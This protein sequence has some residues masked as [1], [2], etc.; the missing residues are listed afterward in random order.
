M[1]RYLNRDNNAFSQARKLFFV[2]KSDC[3]SVLN[4]FINSGLQFICVS[5]PRRFG[6]SR[7][8]SLMNAYYSKGCDS[9]ALFDDLK[10]AKDQSYLENL[11][12][13]D[14]IW[15]D[16]QYEIVSYK[17]NVNDIV[18]VITKNIIK[19]LEENF[20]IEIP[21]TTLAKALAL[22]YDKFKKQFIIIIDE[23]DAIF[24]EHSHDTELEKKY[25]DFLRA[26]FKG[27]TN[28]TDTIA[29]AYITGILPIKRY[30]SQSAL[31]NF[32]EFTMLAP[33]PFITY[34]GF[35]EEETKELCEKNNL[36]YE[37]ACQWYDGYV[38]GG[39]HMLNPNSVVSYLATRKC[40][41]YWNESSA[42]EAV[43]DVINANIEGVK[44][45]LLK[46]INKHYTAGII[47]SKYQN[48]LTS[49][50][51]KD[52]VITYLVHLGYLAYD[53][54]KGIV[55]IPNK[56]V[57]QALMDGIFSSNKGDMFDLIQESRDLLEHTVN[58][59]CDYVAKAIEKCHDLRC[60][61]IK[62]NNEDSLA[63]VVCYAYFACNEHYLPFIR[64][65]PTGKGFADIVFVPTNPQDRDT[66][67][68]VIEL[69]WDKS[70][71]TALEQIK[72]KNYPSYFENYQSDIVLVGINYDKDTKK[73]TCKIE[74]LEL[75]CKL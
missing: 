9:K 45:Q 5:R 38:I 8:T 72:A 51:N 55:Y 65:F 60:S 25:I 24:R 28:P 2:D 53:E 36:S 70:A 11:N 19:E 3:L 6:K 23:W 62:Y 32:K 46:I 47:F 58:G 40:R 61:S 27:E 54:S 20:K 74:Q 12:K 59:D 39:Y 49:L 33:E 57:R 15:F 71:D 68:L 64:E 14:V 22:I 69:K 13:Y 52:A 41:S 73:H 35:T 75:F 21:D 18:D 30:N 4:Q 63:F 48:D 42:I 34:Y 7:M 44:D 17:G 56:E 66:P 1:S 67:I 37:D 43:S 29:L 16:L 26:L 10:I 31:N 50:T